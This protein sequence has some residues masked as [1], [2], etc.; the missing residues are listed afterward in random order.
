MHLSDLSKRN[1]TAHSAVV[2]LAAWRGRRWAGVRT[3][4]AGAA[5]AGAGPGQAAPAAAVAAALPHHAAAAGRRRG[6]QQ[7]RRRRPRAPPA[8]TCTL[9]HT[10]LPLQE[11]VKDKQHQQLLSPLPFPTMLLLLAATV[12]ANDTVI[13]D[14]EDHTRHTGPY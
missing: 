10:T 4:G 8:G 7:H 5:A 12:A 11:I 6:R 3:H 13:A 14:P 1:F 9:H 2:L